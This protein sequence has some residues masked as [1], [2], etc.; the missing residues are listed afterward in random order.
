[1][2]IIVLLLENRRILEEIE[3][4]VFDN[5]HE[6]IDELK[7]LGMTSDEEEHIG[8]Y[9]ISTFMDLVNDRIIENL[10]ETYFGH[11]RINR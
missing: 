10:E 1:M 7:N 3:N 11:V 9:E 4:Q 8:Y 2:K 6:M 5:T